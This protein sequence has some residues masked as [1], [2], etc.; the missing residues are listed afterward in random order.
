MQG[1]FP[2]SKGDTWQRTVGQSHGNRQRFC[3]P[4]IPECGYPPC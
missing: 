1:K 3:H 2:P 4:A